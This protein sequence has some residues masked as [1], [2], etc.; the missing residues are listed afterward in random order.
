MSHRILLV[1]DDVE[2]VELMQD[3]LSRDGFSVAT[4]HTGDAAI[5]AARVGR[6]DLIVLDI[7][8][9][10]VN[11]IEALA[12]IRRF[13]NMPVI[14]L[15]A[16]GDDDDRVL[17]LELGADDY[18]AKPCTPREL[19]ARVRSIMR[20]TLTMESAWSSEL[21]VGP[22]SIWPGQRR[23]S[24]DGQDLALTSTEFSMLALL[25][26]RAGMLVGR[27]DF[28]REVLGRPFSRFDRTIDVHISRLR[29]KLNGAGPG[30]LSIQT[31]IHQGY[32][33]VIH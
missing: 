6:Q 20:R 14:L 29:N 24:L 21:S 17:G 32:Q 22:L 4:A 10:G 1:D 13:S 11:G 5:D 26:R 2:L 15:T 27:E 18:V 9:P 23:A 31:I 7:M 28:S 19:A 3:Y 16:K 12:A 33:L 30:S 8:M 25:V